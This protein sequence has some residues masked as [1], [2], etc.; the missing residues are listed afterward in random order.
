MNRRNMMPLAILAV[1]ISLSPRVARAAAA[2][3]PVAIRDVRIDDPFWTPKREVWRKVTIGD[4]FDKFE[5]DGALT[6][7]DKVRDGTGGEH[8][9]PP[10]YDGLVYEMITG[11][12]DFMSERPDPQ[13]SEEHTSELQSPV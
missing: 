4:C 5:K 2:L 6:N 1:A 13:R 12:A 3:A 8:G 10:W 11:S 7:F 9:G